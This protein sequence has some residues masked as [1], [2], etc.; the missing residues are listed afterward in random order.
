[1]SDLRKVLLVDDEPDIVFVSTMALEKFGHM[2]VVSAS[3]GPEAIERLATIEPDVVLLDMMMPGMDGL[4]VLSAIR[5]R[6]QG[7][8]Y[9]VIFMTAKTQRTEIDEY[10]KAG[11]V[12]VIH[13]PFDPM[14]L[15]SLIKQILDDQRP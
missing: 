15:P 11:A 1:M 5:E 12:G 7:A 4:E 3:S 9:P 14:Q 2:E 6:Y 13:K 10:L 8:K